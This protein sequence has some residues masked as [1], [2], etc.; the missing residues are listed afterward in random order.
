M[1]RFAVMTFGIP[2]IWR[3]ASHT[4]ENRPIVFDLARFNINWPISLETSFR[5]LVA[6]ND[7]PFSRTSLSLY[8]VPKSPPK[9]GESLAAL[10]FRKGDPVESANYQR[11]RR[12]VGQSADC[13]GDP[14]RSLI[15]AKDC[16]FPRSPP[17]R[18]PVVRNS[19]N[20]GESLA[21][22][23]G[24]KGGQR[25]R[26]MSIANLPRSTSVAPEFPQIRR[27]LSRD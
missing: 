27:I 17:N 23:R 19:P 6:A 7:C 18:R 20:F 8:E 2:Q 26:T 21:A 25:N 11:F 3:I 24:Q 10:I 16:P 22:T 9:F 13:Y 15:A 14:F 12:I 5:A 4:F 1:P